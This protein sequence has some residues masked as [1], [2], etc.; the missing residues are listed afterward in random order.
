[1]IHDES[2]MATASI[3]LRYNELRKTVFPG[4]LPTAHTSG[5]PTLSPND[6][7]VKAMNKLRLAK[8]I[9]Y[10]SIIGDRGRGD[11]PDS[12]DGVPYWSSHFEG[13]ASEMIVPSNHNANQ[14]SQGIA[15]VVRILKQH[16]G[17]RSQ[18]SGV[19]GLL[20]NKNIQR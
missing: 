10:R 16:V 12:S 4:A 11:T 19:A 17:R 18:R 8:G 3:P 2:P 15:E 13:A 1:M 20:V 6:A 7:F 14:S 5:M 9:P